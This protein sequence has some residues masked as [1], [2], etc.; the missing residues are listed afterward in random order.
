MSLQNKTKN[1]PLIYEE[2]NIRKFCMVISLWQLKKID[3]V[4]ASRS[5]S[6]DCSFRCIC[7]FCLFHAASAPY[8][9]KSLSLKWTYIIQQTW[10]MNYQSPK[11]SLCIFTGTVPQMKLELVFFSSHCT[12]LFSELLF[13]IKRQILIIEISLLSPTS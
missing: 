13:C 2:Q 7:I 4:G 10:L 8:K 11:S 6:G 3:W 9:I 12:K 5:T 1:V